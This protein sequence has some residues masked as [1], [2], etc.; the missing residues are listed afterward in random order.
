MAEPQNEDQ[1]DK[2]PFQFVTWRE[3]SNTSDINK[4]LV[5]LQNAFPGRLIEAWMI[6]GL[7]IIAR[8]PLPF[9]PALAPLIAKSNLT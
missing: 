3:R 8:Q 6:E 2:T 4:D 7:P 1:M 9:L 5:S